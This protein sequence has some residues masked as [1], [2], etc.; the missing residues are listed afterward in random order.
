MIDYLRIRVMPVLGTSPA[1]FGQAMAAHTLCTIAGKCLSFCFYK[2]NFIEW[3]ML[4][5][6]FE[7][8]GVERLSKNLKHKLRQVFRN[9]ELARFKTDQEIDLIDEDI[10]F[11]V[12]QVLCN[13]S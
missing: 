9:N 12:Q 10:E 8:E 5:K 13:T 2:K 11:V 7:A 4:A 6:P 3:L 1:I